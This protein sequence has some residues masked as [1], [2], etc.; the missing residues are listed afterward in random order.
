MNAAAPRTETHDIVVDEI[1]P[2]APETIWKA[3]T[4]GDLIGRWIMQPTGFAPVKGNR[5]TFQTRAAGVRQASEQHRRRAGL[6]PGEKRDEQGLLRVRRG[7]LR[8]RGH[9]WDRID[10]ALPQFEKMP[11]M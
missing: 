9:A 6:K 3:L 5:F 1:F 10:P 2:H 4:T 7:P 11:P 8:M